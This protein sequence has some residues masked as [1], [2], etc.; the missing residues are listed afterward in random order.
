MKF[1]DNVPEGASIIN[2]EGEKGK[3]LFYLPVKQVVEEDVER[4]SEQYKR[5]SELVEKA[6]EE[7]LLAVLGALS[8]EEAL[9]LF[10]GAWIIDYVRLEKQRDFTFYLKIELLRSLRIIPIHILDAVT[11]INSVRNKFA[12]EIKIDCFDS[13][14]NGTKEILKQKHKMFFPKDKDTSITVKKMFIAIVEGVL[15]ALGIYTTHVKFARN[16]IYSEDFIK[17]LDEYIKMQKR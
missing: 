5:Y 13:L 1:V 2:I 17:K 7:R 3:S 6:K 14:D 15:I 9:D 8:V 12:H 16:Y 10:L 11:L 4:I